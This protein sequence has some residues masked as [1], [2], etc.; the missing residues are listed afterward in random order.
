MPQVGLHRPTESRC[1]LLVELP[2]GYVRKFVSVSLY[3]TRFASQAAQDR[4][5]RHVIVL[6]DVRTVNRR[7]T[8]HVFPAVV[9]RST[10]LLAHAKIA[11]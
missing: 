10:N 7:V 5:G 6:A 3:R 1:R 8:V 11:Q 4:T 9:S 2:V